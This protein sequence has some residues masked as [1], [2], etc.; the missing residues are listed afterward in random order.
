MDADP[1]FMARPVELMGTTKQIAKTEQLINDVLVE[2]GLVIG[3][4]GET[5]K[6]MKARIGARIQVI[7]L[8]LPPS[9][10][11]IER[12]FHIDGTSE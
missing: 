4:G 6:N 11:S 12:S 7:P 8:H 9:D 1:N 5:I 3:K 10:P 2:V